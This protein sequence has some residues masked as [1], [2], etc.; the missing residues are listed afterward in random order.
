MKYADQQYLR[1]EH[2]LHKGRYV[3]A[4]VTIKDIVTDCPIKKGDKDGFTTG[5]AFEKSDKV[6]GLNKTNFSMICWSTGEGKPEAWIGKQIT[7]VV[8]LVRNR[9]VIEPGIRVWPD[10]PMPNSRVREQLGE[11]ITEDWY[12]RNSQTTGAVETTNTDQHQE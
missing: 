3:A 2:L 5:I 4:R 1:A 8:R 12:K 10:K 11:E 7:L 9:K 6:L